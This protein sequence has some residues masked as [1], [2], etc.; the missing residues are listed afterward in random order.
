MR[1]AAGLRSGGRWNGIINF[2][3]HVVS[4]V[5]VF[6]AL[7]TG[8]LVGSSFISRGTVAVLQASLR[9]LDA[10]NRNLI[11]EVRDLKNQRG[12]LQ[13]F[14]QSSEAF[15]VQGRLKDRPVVLV[16][17]DTTP[18][19]LSDAVSQTLVAAGARVQ[20]SVQLSSKL[21]FSNQARR[22]RAAQVLGAPS[23]DPDVLARFLVNGLVASLSG[24]A[25][26]MVSKLVEG[27]LASVREVSGGKPQAL[28]SLAAPGSTVIVLGGAAKARTELDQRVAGPLAQSLAALE[29]S[30]V[31]VGVAEPGPGPFQV[32][33]RL[34]GANLRLVTADGI[35]E[36]MGRIQLVLGLQ[37]AAAG[38]FGDYGTGPG[39]S[40]I[41]PSG[42][43]TPK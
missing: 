23:A 28:G 30:P 10:S 17:I 5:A 36:P 7:G 12:T 9:K 35:D 24:Q 16:S 42:P 22:E 11:D 39:A 15:V 41:L 33:P 38:R 6:L 34:R 13:D 31:L 32:M 29:G 40:S 37:A 26:G 18:D 27:G 3:Y 20:G 1:H 2:R 19:D 8:A 25:P 4:L 14:V 21:D 43:D